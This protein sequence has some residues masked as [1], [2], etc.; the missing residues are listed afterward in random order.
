[1]TFDCRTRRNGGYYEKQNRKK[2]KRE[3]RSLPAYLHKDKTT[4]AVYVILR[5]FVLI[6]LAVS[7][8]RQN[9]E[10]VFVC[11][12][13]LLLYQ[14]PTFIERSLKIELPTTLEVIVLL[15]IF[16]AE[17]LGE[18]QS[19][20]VK[21]P[22]WDTM[23][24]TVNGFLFAA[25]GF[26]LIDIINRNK[27]F[28]IKMSPLYLAIVAFCFS[29]TIGVLWEFFEFGCDMVLKTDM[30]KDFVVNRFSSVMLNPDGI[31]IPIPVENITDVAVNGQSLGLNGY[32]DIGLIDTMKD[33]LVNFVGAVIFS[34]IGFIYVKG[35]DK[36]RGVIARQFIPIVL[37]DETEQE[38][39]EPKET[40]TQE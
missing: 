8:F 3:K 31:N 39:A 18:L 1:M 2:Q 15:F 29:M 23:L 40:K 35:R 20:Y 32:L 9:Y 16:A 6:A 13:T 14:V 36:G 10:N 28:S 19:Y 7:L 4:V 33:L 26:A 17:I 12:L 30:Q 25:F 34:I 21:F 5:I 24:H 27:K 11:F 38:A 22:Y 37:D